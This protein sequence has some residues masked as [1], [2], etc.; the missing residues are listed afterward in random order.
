MKHA[1]WIVVAA[2]AAPIVTTTAAAQEPKAESHSHEYVKLEDLPP[3]VKA[4]VERE[5]QGKTIESIEKETKR[6]VTVYEV[7]LLLSNGQEQEIEI[8]ET[9]EV[10]E[11][12]P[13][14]PKKTEP[15]HGTR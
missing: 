14:H 1:R 12:E 7:D 15:E 6:G 5:A 11:R 3:P 10:I 4:T 8:S 2:L 9:G 13:P